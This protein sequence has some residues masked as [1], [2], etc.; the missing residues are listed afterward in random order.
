[1]KKMA[2]K[3]EP[4]QQVTNRGAPRT[5]NDALGAALGFCAFFALERSCSC[6]GSRPGFDDT[7]ESTAVNFYTFSTIAPRTVGLTANYKFG[8][9]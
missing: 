1:M 6:R 7:Q 3:C 9:L 4:A 5:A 2:R 8:A